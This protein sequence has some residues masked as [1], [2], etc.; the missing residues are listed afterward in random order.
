[1]KF[2]P[3]PWSASPMDMIFDAE[4]KLIATCWSVR[5]E[6]DPAAAN[7]VL[8]SRAP[9]LFE[10]LEWLCKLKEYK[11]SGDQEK[12]AIHESSKELAWRKANQLLKEITDGISI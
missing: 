3:A 1:M 5:D 10:V 9:E 11:N 6:D 2:S 12:M 4:A 7:A 8:M